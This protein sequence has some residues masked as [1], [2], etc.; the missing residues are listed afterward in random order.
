MSSAWDQ[1][2]GR[3]P[4]RSRHVRALRRVAKLRNVAPVADNA[5]R[6]KVEALAENLLKLRLE[7][8]EAEAVEAAVKDFQATFRPPGREGGGEGASGKV[9]KFSA[10]QLTYNASHGDWVA[11]NTDQLRD[12]FSRFTTFLGAV[13]QELSAIGVS[14]TMERASAR[15]VHTHAYLHLSKPYHRRGAEALAVFRFEGVRPH[16]TPNTASGKSYPGAMRFGHFYVVCDKKGTLFT[17]TDFPPFKSYGV[18]GWWLDNL[19]KAGKLDREVYLRLAAQVTVGFQKRLADCRAAERLEHDLAVQEAVDAAAADL[20]VATLP[21]KRFAVVEDFIACHDGTPSFRRPVLA[22]VGGTRLGKSMLAA[23]I[24]GR[25]ACKL[26]VPSFL[27][28]TVEDSQQMDLADFDRR[29][30]A[31]VILD[32]VGDAF[33]LKRNR[34]ALQG[35]PKIVKGARSATNVYSYKFSFCGRAVVVTFDLSAENLEALRSD[36]W[37]SNREN[38]QL[39]WLT[40]PAYEEP[41]LSAIEL[42]TASEAS[43]RKRRWIGSPARGASLPLSG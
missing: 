25:I 2:H 30:H 16:V 29:K 36:H 23:D 6:A 8:D 17:Q 22:I 13:K 21:M 32:G 19:L 39:L 33:F 14:A 1:S 9:W 18:E 20:R 38:V 41:E 42:D 4:E 5:A 12:L 3:H 43:A 34:E 37:L 24:L 27:E 7:P 40:S 26:G 11:S 15:Q 31:G 35:R 28:V 10:V